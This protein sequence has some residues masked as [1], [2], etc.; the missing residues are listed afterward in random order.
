MPIRYL[1]ADIVGS[2]QLGDSDRAGLVSCSER[3]H[4]VR[5]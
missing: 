2:D 5:D 4:R 1:A 3:P